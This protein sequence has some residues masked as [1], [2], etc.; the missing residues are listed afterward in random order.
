M[1]GQVRNT[2]PHGLLLFIQFPST[3]SRAGRKR[4]SPLQA[5]FWPPLMI[6]FPPRG[7]G[8]SL[9]SVLALG[10]SLIH[11]GHL[12]TQNGDQKDNAEEVSEDLGLPH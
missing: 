2:C 5:V 10:D 9:C 4:Q 8:G 12:S 6:L 7:T 11:L 1:L 3:D